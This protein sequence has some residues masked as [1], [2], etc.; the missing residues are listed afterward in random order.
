[1]AADR[2][3]STMEGA[4]EWPF[5][6]RVHADSSATYGMAAASVLA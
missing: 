4:A 5:R 3:T 2:N 6:I 1:M